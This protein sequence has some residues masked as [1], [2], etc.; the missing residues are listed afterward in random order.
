[1]RYRMTLLILLALPS[2][3]MAEGFVN[4]VGKM[5]NGRE[6]VVFTEPPLSVS[7][8][9]RSKKGELVGQIHN[10]HEPCVYSNHHDGGEE[11]RTL[12]CSPSARSE[13]AGATYVGRRIHRDC[14]ESDFEFRYRCTKGCG[15]GSLAPAV[16]TQNFWEC[17]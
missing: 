9:V 2:V 17:A 10:D 5:R 6:I 15:P 8:W 1:M 13:L 7:T 14:E 3:A 11:V 12:V 4:L 16:L